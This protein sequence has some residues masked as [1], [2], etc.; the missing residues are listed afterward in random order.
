MRLSRELSIPLA[1]ARRFIDQYFA[2]MPAVKGYLEGSL[3]KA[4]RDGFVSTVLGR[5]RYLPGLGSGDARTRSSAER[6]AA[7]TP[8]QGS[9]AD[10]I[11]RA[12][13][14]L[15]ARLTQERLE[16]RLILQ[17]HDE[18]LLEGPSGERERVVDALRSSMEG[19]IALAVPLKVD[20]GWGANWDEAH[21]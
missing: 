15:R 5:R 19:A 21:G 16:T 4:R 11:K 13:I 9:A 2:K 18:L 8:I 3:E 10:L 6:V 1:E 20:V 12:M 14:R 17:V 7:N